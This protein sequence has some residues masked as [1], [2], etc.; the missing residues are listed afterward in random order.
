M[1]KRS[2]RG[3]YAGAR[4]PGGAIVRDTSISIPGLAALRTDKELNM[5]DERPDRRNN[6]A[7]AVFSDVA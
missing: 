3:I 1:D 7:R 4:L 5:A 6:V 2:G